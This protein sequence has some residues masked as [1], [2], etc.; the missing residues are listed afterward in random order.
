MFSLDLTA[1]NVADKHAIHNLLAPS[2][3]RTT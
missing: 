2:A 1:I 3:E